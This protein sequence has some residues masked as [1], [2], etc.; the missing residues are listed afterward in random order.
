MDE[1]LEAAEAVEGTE[2]EGPLVML[3]RVIG[4][5]MIL[6]GLGLWLFTEMTLLWVPALL[7]VVGIVLVTIPGIAFELLGG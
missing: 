7:V 1:A 5:I 4:A 6:A 2:L 3:F